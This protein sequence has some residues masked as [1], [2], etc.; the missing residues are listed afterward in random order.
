MAIT[1]VKFANNLWSTSGFQ[2]KLDATGTY[3]PNNGNLVLFI[4]ICAGQYLPNPPTGWANVGFILNTTVIGKIWDSSTDSTTAYIGGSDWSSQIYQGYEFSG[5]D[6]SFIEAANL[7][8]VDLSGGLAPVPL[9]P[10]TFTSVL[11]GC[12][13]ITLVTCPF[14]AWGGA[15]GIYISSPTTPTETD[16]FTYDGITSTNGSGVPS[17]S[18]SILGTILSLSANGITNGPTFAPTVTLTD[19]QWAVAG[20]IFG[21]IVIKPEVVRPSISIYSVDGET[22]YVRAEQAVGTNSRVQAQWTCPGG[23]TQIVPRLRSDMSA[24]ELAS[25]KAIWSQPQMEVGST[26]TAYKSGPPPAGYGKLP[27]GLVNLIPDS[28]LALCSFAPV[29]GHPDFALRGDNPSMWTGNFLDN[30]SAYLEQGTASNGSCSFQV[31]ND[32]HAYWLKSS[33]ISVVAGVIYTLS[34]YI[35][36]RNFS[37]GPAFAGIYDPTGATQYLELDGSPGH[38]GRIQAQWLCPAGGSVVAIA[39][40][41]QANGAVRVSSSTGTPN[42]VFAIP[43]LEAGASMSAYTPGATVTSGGSSS[44]PSGGLVVGG[45]TYYSGNGVP[46]FAANAGD[47]YTNTAQ[48]PVPGAIQYMNAGG[49][50]WTAYA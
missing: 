24:G 32:A 19:S 33:T 7:T 27:T 12:A 13:A 43:Q 31:D 48:P 49:S 20:L 44:F 38:N 29:S 8:N 30:I 50:S 34:V 16:G 18:P 17:G 22:E 10:N 36:M 39:V 40:M 28:N 42:L 26:M 47:L 45:V 14:S 35:D 4:C 11:P 3:Q 41:L 2:A 37:G 15:T 25:G 9:N 1:P 6:L 21:L 23:V 5:T 46:T